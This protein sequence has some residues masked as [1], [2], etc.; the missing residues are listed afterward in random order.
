MPLS[1]NQKLK[2]E[3]RLILFR[4]RSGPLAKYSENIKVYPQDTTGSKRHPS[5]TISGFSVARGTEC[6]P[7]RLIYGPKVPQRVPRKHKNIIIINSY[8]LLPTPKRKMLKTLKKTE[9][10][11]P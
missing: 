5:G 3:H 7:R 8:V 2:T 9:N 6:L 4:L 10:R 11:Q 1:G